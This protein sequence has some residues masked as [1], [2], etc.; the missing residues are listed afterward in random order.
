[1]DRTH[2]TNGREYARLSNLKAGDVVDL[3]GG[4]TCGISSRRLPV[5][6]DSSGLYVPC[7]EGKHYLDGQIDDAGDHLIGVYPAASA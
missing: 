1:M 6:A 2:D 5:E 4:F 7:G 3:D